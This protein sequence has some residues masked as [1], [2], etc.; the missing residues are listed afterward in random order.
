MRSLHQKVLEIQSEHDH[1]DTGILAFV[2]FRIK[3]LQTNY[4]KG[5]DK[6]GIN[7]KYCSDEYKS[8]MMTDSNSVS[9]YYEG[10]LW[11]CLLNETNIS[12]FIKGESKRIHKKSKDFFAVFC[13]YEGYNSFLFEIKNEKKEEKR[14]EAKSQINV[15]VHQNGKRNTNIEEI[16]T[17]NLYL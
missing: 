3:E 11:K 17:T 8:F 9:Q 12:K 1:V 5:Q 10:L 15:T 13:G 14:S 6:K 7:D 2:N 4:Q 16:N